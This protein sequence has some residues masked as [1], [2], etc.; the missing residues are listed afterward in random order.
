M[1]NINDITY[2]I[3]GCAYEVHKILG[4]GLLESTYETCLCYEL[5]KQGLKFEKQKELMI[6]YKGTTLNNGYRIDI[7]VE[8]SIVLELKSVEN[9]LPIH[10]A[11]ILT[12]LKLSEHNLGLLINF[13]VTNLQNGIHR[14]II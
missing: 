10:T 9:L 2:K 4:P 1:K 14:Y 6:N 12:Y 3:I 11:Q 7:L 8:D 5:E 13:N